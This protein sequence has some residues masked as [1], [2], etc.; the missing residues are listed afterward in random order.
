M[1]NLWT[2][3]K[4]NVF[5]YNILTGD[6]YLG[7]TMFKK[8][9]NNIYYPNI[10]KKKQKQRKINTTVRFFIVQNYVWC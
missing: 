8:S 9:T 6:M 10:Y 2:S 3:T 4:Q 7:D 1:Q 5:V